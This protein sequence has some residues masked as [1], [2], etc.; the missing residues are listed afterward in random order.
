MGYLNGRLIGTGIAIWGCCGAV[1]GMA[2]S[3]TTKDNALIIHAAATPV[4][5]AGLTYAYYRSTRSTRLLVTAAV[6]TV[7]PMA[8]DFGVV[9]TLLLRS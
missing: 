9:A 1:M 6:V 5:A 7:I 2:Q 4:I 3:L 8:L